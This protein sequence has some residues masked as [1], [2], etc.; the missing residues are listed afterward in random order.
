MYY[1]NLKVDNSVHTTI[2]RNFDNVLETRR[3]RME[4]ETVAGITSN[5][6]FIAKHMNDYE[7]NNVD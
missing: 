2:L 6:D 4:I 3:Q 7:K 1:Y 5:L